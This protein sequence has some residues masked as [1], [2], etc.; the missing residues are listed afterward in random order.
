MI[1]P[2]EP[3]PAAADWHARLYSSLDGRWTCDLL[4]RDGHVVASESFAT[5]AECVAAALAHQ[6]PVKGLPRALIAKAATPVSPKEKPPQAGLVIQVDGRGLWRWR[7]L[8]RDGVELH[9]A[10]CAFLTREECMADASRFG[11]ARRTSAASHT[12][13]R[14]AA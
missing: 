10:A 3:Q 14:L 7:H 1:R 4:T 8:D 2:T 12:G 13:A 11:I 9:A 6:V 5:R